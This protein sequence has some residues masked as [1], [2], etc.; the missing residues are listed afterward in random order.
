MTLEPSVAVVVL[1]AELLAG[2]EKLGARQQA[3]ELAAIEVGADRA[4]G[5]L[6]RARRGTS[7]PLLEARIGRVVAGEGR[8]EHEAPGLR[9]AAQ[10]RGQVVDPRPRQ[11]RD[12][13]EDEH[14]G[15][16]RRRFVGVE[17]VG[18]HD[19]VE[20]LGRGGALELGARHRRRLEGDDR[21]AGVRDRQG[22]ST[23]A[24]A[25]VE[26]GTVRERGEEVEQRS[27]GC[28]AEQVGDVP[29][30]GVVVVGRGHGVG[31]VGPGSAA[32]VSGSAKLPQPARAM[33]MR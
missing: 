33:A 17:A 11:D 12:Q 32:G 26:H 25:D 5:A 8:H 6:E 10:A 14:R 18:Q 20:S 24:G 13:A 30:A 22:V 7:P 21:A 2:E 3:G 28:A 9:E 1:G 4:V 23:L 15:V 31:G 16:G 27:L 19:D 29:V